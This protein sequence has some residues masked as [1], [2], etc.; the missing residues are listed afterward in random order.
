MSNAKI[1]KFVGQWVKKISSCKIYKCNHCS[2]ETN[3]KF[4]KKSLLEKHIKEFHLEFFCNYCASCG[5]TTQ[6]HLEEHMKNFHCF[7]CNLCDHASIFKTEHTLKKH[8]ND[9]HALK[10]EFCNT[11]DI[12]TKNALEEHMKSCQHFICTYLY[13][14]LSISVPP[15]VCS[16]AI[17]SHIYGQIKGTYGILGSRQT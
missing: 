12:F 15:S 14:N 13:N 9:K 5:F 10:C 16:D 7:K 3:N 2:D 11:N 1:S 17:S 8:M 4:K 6:S